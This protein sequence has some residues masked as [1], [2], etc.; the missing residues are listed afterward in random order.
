MTV[1]G[2]SPF[3]LDEDYFLNFATFLCEKR[4]FRVPKYRLLAESEVFASK[5]GLATD[6][7]PISEYP[8]DPLVSATPLDV[9][10]DDFRNFLKVMYPKNIEGN[11]YLEPG[12]WLSVL[13]LSTDWHFN[14]LRKRSITALSTE[15]KLGPVEKVALG[16]KYNVSHWLMEGF[17]QLVT[18][19]E[20]ITIADAE[21]IRW[22]SAITLYSIRDVWNTTMASKKD[23]DV[24]KR[25]IHDAFKDD[26]QAMYDV[27]RL[28][29]TAREKE[30]KKLKELE[31]KKQAPAPVRPIP[32]GE[33]LR[34]QQAPIDAPA[35]PK[36]ATPAG[37]A[38]PQTQPASA[39]ASSSGNTN[40]TT[41][42][43][44]TVVHVDKL[45]SSGPAGAAPEPPTT[46]TTATETT[47]QVTQPRKRA[48]KETTPPGTRPCAAAGLMDARTNSTA[49]SSSGDFLGVIRTGKTAGG[50]NMSS[51]SSSL[52]SSTFTFSGKLFTGIS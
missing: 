9:S 52:N 8:D 6:T 34:I 17:L 28:H 31:L 2:T 7:Y 45:L 12:E 15:Y 19:K 46:A 10:A 20:V 32:A 18:R 47:P 41:K 35:A 4:L 43:Y 48:Q 3:E 39:P 38:V 33:P 25:M 23:E 22:Q 11:L 40:A 29:L 26:L 49:P 50:L 42:Q 36:Q 27:E 13:K 44:R 51:Q 30:G 21:K 24:L 16:L 14:D 5:Y 37:L 1:A